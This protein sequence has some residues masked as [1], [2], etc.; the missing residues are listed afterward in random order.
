MV[1]PEPFLHREEPGL[2]QIP[3]TPSHGALRHLQFPSHSGYR[4]P[5]EALLVGPAPQV[6]VHGDGPVGQVALV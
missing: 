4:R 2:F 3:H 1:P 6:E 5:A